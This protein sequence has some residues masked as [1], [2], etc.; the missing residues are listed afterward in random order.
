MRVKDYRI[1]ES[2]CPCCGHKV[3][4]AMETVGNTHEGPKSGDWSVCI[5][6][7]G[8]SVYGDDMQLRLPSDEET[9]RIKDYPN[10]EV[11]RGHVMT[12]NVRR[13]LDR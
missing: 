13:L 11:L 6:C 3:D 7:A 10:L 8:I 5:R 2:K 12:A 1:A 9:G 4:S